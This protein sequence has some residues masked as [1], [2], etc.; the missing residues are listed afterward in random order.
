MSLTS[1]K[2]RLALEKPLVGESDCGGK[3]VAS[4]NYAASS[5]AG[6]KAAAREARARGARGRGFMAL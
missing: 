1:W 4:A 3:L 2:C 5:M 6:R